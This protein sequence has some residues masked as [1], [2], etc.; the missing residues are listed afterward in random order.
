MSTEITEVVEEVVEN[1]A[2]VEETVEE[3][4]EQ[5]TYTDEEI[6]AMD[7]GW[8]PK[9]EWKGD[10]SDWV[11]AKEFNRRGEL[12][13]KIRNLERDRETNRQAMQHMK[14][15]LAKAKETEYNR[16]LKELKAE[17]KVAA[18]EGETGKML[19]IDDQIEELKNDHT[20]FVQTAQAV[21]VEPAQT[22]EAFIAWQ[23]K[24]H[25]YTED[26]DMR[27]FAD[28][29][30]MTF[31]NAN[32]GASP[33]QV[34]AAVDKQMRRAYPEKF[35]NPKRTSTSKVESTTTGG[36]SSKSKYSSKDLND[37]QRDIMRTMTRSGVMTEE[38]YINE[39]VRIG[40]IG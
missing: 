15:L 7:H 2:P 17:K 25:W 12:F 32:P 40:E 38:E 1:A 4:T 30:G 33:D 36:K 31:A 20:E 27:N 13:G 19:E 9:E 34:F 8:A 26:A 16:A 37:Q 14:D 35:S 22:N 29:A 24:N 3:V 28:T 23:Q 18:E 10:E 5:P 11:S 39:L 6:Q 21:P